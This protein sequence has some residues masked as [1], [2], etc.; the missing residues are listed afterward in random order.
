MTRTST[1]RAS[2]IRRGTLYAVA[3]VGSWMVLTITLS[4][5]T[6]TVT[7][8]T[9]LMMSPTPSMIR[10]TLPACQASL[11]KLRDTVAITRG[12]SGKIFSALERSALPGQHQLLGTGR[13]SGI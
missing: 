8:Q 12:V 4:V 10:E 2:T 9:A 11:S 5:A 6:A 3:S 7:A 1:T 13:E